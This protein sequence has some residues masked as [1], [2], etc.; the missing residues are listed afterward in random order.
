MFFPLLYTQVLCQSRLWKADRASRTY[1][2]LQWQ[3]S[4]L[5]ILSLTAAKPD[6]LRVMLRPTVNRPVCLD[7]KPP[8]GAQDQIFITVRELRGFLYVGCPRWREDE[9]VIYNC[10]W[11]SPAQSFSGPSHA[12]LMT[13]FYSLRFDT[14]TTWRSG[15]CIYIPQEQGGPVIS[16]GTGFP[17]R[18]LLRLA[19]LRWR[20]SNQPPRGG[21]QST[22]SQSY[23]T[24]GSLPQ[25]SSSWCQAP[26]DSRRDLFF[27]FFFGN[28]NLVF[29]IR[30]E[31][32]SW[33]EDGFVSY[34]L[35]IL[36]LSSSLLIAHIACYWKFF[37]LY[38]THIKVL[39]Y[40]SYAKTAA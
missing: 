18:R 7:A 25:I 4:H 2:M 36:A 38:Y 8:S 40:V 35:D 14:P 29:I 37:F 3:L 15:P 23:F 33:R 20:C 1:L 22:Q 5:N 24:T 17:F 13:I 39:C 31:H 12:E 6:K 19:G 27:F 34:I 32:P 9:S 26:W 11:P 10:C 16:L 28:W 30:M 21:R